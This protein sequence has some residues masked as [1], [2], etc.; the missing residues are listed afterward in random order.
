MTPGGAVSGFIVSLP[1]TVASG[2]MP[3]T[4]SGRIPGTSW[5][6]RKSEN[7]GPISGVDGCPIC[8]RPGRA[9]G[10]TKR[11]IRT[12]RIAGIASFNDTLGDVVRRGLRSANRA[13]ER[14][15]NFG[16]RF[17]N[18]DAAALIG[19]ARPDRTGGKVDLRFVIQ[20]RRIAQRVDDAGSRLKPRRE[21]RSALHAIALHRHHARKPAEG[22]GRRHRKCRQQRD[23][24]QHG[25]QNHAAA[26]IAAFHR[27]CLCGLGHVALC[28]SRDVQASDRR[29]RLPAGC[30]SIGADHEI[31]FTERIGARGPVPQI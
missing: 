3:A 15:D 7:G 20:Q 9:I 6:C 12:R 18:V 13:Q 21:Q 26:R 11:D 14:R 30:R 27:T 19:E 5:S 22:D 23:R 8:R 24:P 17:S 28:R 10:R 4:H 1:N 16:W 29:V 31:G 2:V 25:H